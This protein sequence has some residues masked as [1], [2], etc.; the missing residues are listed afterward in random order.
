MPQPLCRCAIVDWEGVGDETGNVLD[1]TLDGIDA[2]LSLW[3]I[4]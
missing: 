3:P 2:L 1:I 4:F